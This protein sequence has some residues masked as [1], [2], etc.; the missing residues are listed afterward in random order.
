MGDAN[1]NGNSTCKVSS[2]KYRGVYFGENPFKSP[3]SLL[4]AQLSFCSFFTAI[5]GFLLAPLGETAFVSHI[6]VGV[7]LG[8]SLIGKLPIFKDVIFAPQSFYISNTFSFYGVMLFLFI[9]GVKTDLQIISKAGRTALL[10]GISTFFLPLILTLLFSLLLKYS[11]PM[12]PNLHK[13]LHWVASL[14]SLS[15]CHVTI[16]LLAD[17]KLLSSE[18]GKLA[19]TASTISG[20]FSWYWTVFVFVARESAVSKMQDST[21]L[22]C[23]SVFC[24]MVLIVCILKPIM[25]WMIDQSTIEG[26]KVKE[27]HVSIIFI[28]VLCF[29]MFGEIIGQH[30]LFGPMML[31][32]AVPDGPPLGSA[33]VGKLECFVSYVFMPIFFVLS[34]PSFDLSTIHVGDVGIVELLTFIAYIGKV[35]ATML[36]SIYCK[37]PVNDALYLGLIM[38]CQ[39]VTDVLILGKATQLNLIDGETYTIMVLSALLFTGVIAPIIKALY[40]PSQKYAAYKRRT[41][42]HNRPNTELR[43]LSCI[44][45]QDQTPSVINILESSNPTQKSPICIYV[46]HLVELTGRLAPVIVS[47][48]PSINRTTSHTFQSDRIINAF[49]LYEKQNQRHI[50]VYPFTAIAPYETM[51]D[52]ICSLALDKWVSFIILPFHRSWTV[53]GLED[54]ANAIRAVNRNVLRNAPCSVGI[55]VDRGT[56]SGQGGSK[57]VPTSSYNIG[58]IFL[59]GQDDREA[60]A[61]AR[62]MAKH[63]NANLTVVRLMES[64]CDIH[65]HH[66]TEQEQDSEIIKEFREAMV[67]DELNCEYKEALVEDSVGVVNVIQEVENS[68]DLILVG[69]RRANDSPWS[70]ELREWNEFPELGFIGDMLVSSDS[71]CMVSVLV[72]QQ[73]VL[74]DEEIMASSPK[75][76]S[77]DSSV[78]NIPWQPTKVWPIR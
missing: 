73:Q 76:I 54:S 38:S 49:R 5:V 39:G 7:L 2:G 21:L 75:Y 32:M 34:G 56:I 11:L 58:V 74:V 24:I 42:Q 44:H 33:L 46:I 28:T 18:I 9:V 40:N 51:H 25:L 72:V 69:R 41:I 77:E 26:K 16:C 67:K 27:S 55:L 30:Y 22:I 20:T 57:M 71:K 17:L 63:P 68:F 4:L 70:L 45:H 6:L 23:L 19:I 61:Y 65:Q 35:V 29:T 1:A 59:G 60:L 50:L 12:S 15:S 78:V 53:H 37:M 13:S 3:T 62:R 47:H 14:Q 8:P 66:S 52:E 48:H 31:G 36:P 64:S 10:I 43:F